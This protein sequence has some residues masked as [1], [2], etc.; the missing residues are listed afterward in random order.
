MWA[1]AALAAAALYTFSPELVDAPTFR[2]PLP[3]AVSSRDSARILFLG[4]V[5]F[6]RGIRLAARAQG[7]YG[8]VLA[9]LES[10][11]RAHDIVVFNLE[12]PV[13]DNESASTGSAVGSARNYVFTMDPASLAALHEAAGTT[14]LVANL[15]N[16]HIYNFGMDGVLQTEHNLADEHIMF[17]GSPRGPEEPLALNTSAGR[18]VFVSYNQFGSM[19]VASSAIAALTVARLS[20]TFPVLFAHWGEEYA[21][22]APAYV[23]SLARTFVDA[24]ARLVVGSHPHVVEG[25]VWYADTL[26]F[27]S[28]GNALF[29]QYWDPSVY[30]GAALSVTIDHGALTHAEVVPL[31]MMRSGQTLF[32]PEATGC[33]QYGSVVE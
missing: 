31:K 19:D 22:S 29:D 17:F 5:M 4:D 33:V 32:G 12:G 28:L 13:T 1:V 6:D 2:A 21:T 18:V 7:G 14:T 24:G 23:A 27:Y 26:I 11:L 8:Y 20:G 16:N 10:L 30:C 3:P 15:G 25:P 9:P